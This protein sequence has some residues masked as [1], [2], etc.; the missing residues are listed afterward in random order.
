MSLMLKQSLELQSIQNIVALLPY[1]YH[2]E[3]TSVLMDHF[4]QEIRLRPNQSIEVV[5]AG[6]SFFLKNTLFNEADATFVLN[7]LSQHSIYAFEEELRH[8][9]LTLRGGH[10]VGIAGE[11]VV[12]KGV[13]KTIKHIR[14]FNIRISRALEKVS[15]PYLQGLYEGRWKTSIVAGPPQSGKTTI[16]RDLAKIISNGYERLNIPPQ[17]VAIVDERS[18]IAASFEGTPQHDVGKRTDV[19][20]RCPKAEGMMMLIRSMSPNVIIVDEVG[21]EADI[22]AIEEAASAGVA[23]LCSAHAKSMNDLE[24]RGV[25]SSDTFEGIL[26][27]NDKKE[28]HFVHKKRGK[29]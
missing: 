1:Q 9:F 13:V 2:Q 21:S 20:D 12:E 24:A 7:Q 19:L 29:S 14:T 10:R 16:L 5:L 4:V 6:E 8:G 28:G 27:L 25:I 23:V 22:R 26:L 3:L 15:V 18:E 17:K 11:A